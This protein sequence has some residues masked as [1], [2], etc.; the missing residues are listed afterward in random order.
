MILIISYWFG[1]IGVRQCK[2]IRTFQVVEG[3]KGHEILILVKK[4]CKLN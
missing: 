1:Q 3:T 4:Y 2:Y